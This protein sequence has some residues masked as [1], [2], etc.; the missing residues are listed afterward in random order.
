MGIAGTGKR[1]VGEA[2]AKQSNFKFVHH[3]SWIDPILNLLGTDSSVFW[4]L[5]EKSW[6]KLNEARDVIFSTMTNVC[7]EDTNFIITYEMLD[8]DPYHQSFYE[9]VLEVLKK[10]NAYFLPV[11]L[12]CDEDE[13]LKRV[14][15]EDRK[16]YFKTRD[17]Q[18][19]QNRVKEEKV[20]YTKHKNEITLD[21]TKML[22][23]DAAKKILSILQSKVVLN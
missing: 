4:D 3:H 14:E 12:I 6:A 1:T 7:P 17:V 20:F 16:Q 23:D 19:I 18:L 10:R 15:A 13:L 2:L 5:E 22:P 11:R 21:I 9:H 8:K